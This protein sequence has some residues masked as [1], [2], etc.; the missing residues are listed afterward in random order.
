MRVVLIGSGKIIYFLAQRFASKGYQLMLI[1]PNG[2]E[3]TR[4]SRQLRATVITGDGSNP[5]V[6]EEAETYRADVLL[7]LLPEDHDN[8]VACQIAQRRYGVAQTVA[9]VNDPNNRLIFEKLGITLAFSATELLADAIQQQTE[10]DSIRSLMPVAGGQISVT[11]VTVDA[12]S[13]AVGKSIL[14]LDKSEETIVACL[15][16]G[17]HSFVPKGW[18]VFE[19]GDRLV[20]ISQPETYGPFLKQITGEA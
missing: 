2:A 1:C 14:E 13:P 16:R 5:A 10:F 20:I 8:L 15:V 19:A 6:L 12:Q 4:L 3:A 17:E 7:S 9:L 18:T 11:E